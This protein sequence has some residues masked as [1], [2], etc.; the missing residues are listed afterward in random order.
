[1]TRSL[2][3][4]L[5]IGLAGLQFIAVLAVVFSSYLTSER[6]LIAHARDLL[7]DV[8][9]NTIEHSKSFLSPAEGAAELAAR[10][11]QNQII[12]SDDPNRL[13]QLLFQQLQITPQ[14]AGLYY[15]NQNGE[16]VMVMRN[17]DGRADF[18]SKLVT[19][20]DGVRTV[21]LIWRNDD[22][23]PV[24]TQLDPTDTFDPRDRPWYIDAFTQR[25][26]IWTDPYVFFSSRQPGITLAAP[27]MGPGSTVRGVIG[28]DIEISRISEFLSRLNI[29]EYGKALIIN[30]NGD[31]IAH[32][33]LKL[34]ESRRADGTLRLPRLQE[35]NDPIAR[36]A[37]GP[38][39]LAGAFPVAQETTTE[40]NMPGHPTSRRSCR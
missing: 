22:F 40:S 34:V 31:V 24:H 3:A 30:H 21:Q 28:V 14:F 23:S 25:S 38:Q 20:E 8:G 33:D 1:M 9:S 32:P 5:V 2:G 36:A 12:A 19:L 16:F 13:E 11:A 7:H 4:M 15:G 37:F 10:L 18:R 26:I 6:A 17:P 39:S 29:G 27:V 35:L